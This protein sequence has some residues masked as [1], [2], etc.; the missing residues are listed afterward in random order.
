MDLQDQLQQLQKQKE[1]LLQKQA[2]L[3]EDLK[4]RHSDIYNWFLDDSIDLRSLAKYSANI[5]AALAIV[6]K[7]GD[8]SV[9]W[10]S[11][12]KTEAPKLEPVVRLIEV[13]ELA[14]KTEDEKVKLV[15]ER[16]GHIIKRAAEKY[17]VDEKLILATI[18][19]ESGG[20]TYAVRQEPQIN[21]ASYGL[22]QILYGTARGM[23]FKGSAEEM[24]DPEV[25]IELTARYH[26]RNMDV[27]GQELTPTQL[28]TAY[29]AGSPY[30]TPY[31][32]HLTK[33]EKWYEKVGNLLV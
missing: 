29:N 20:N 7:P 27:Y 22:G 21:D 17:S 1:Q 23:G 30:S 16:Y 15:Q 13:D 6:L 18:M 24:F 4:V 25:N 19:L 5:A 31:P 8:F 10:V 12:K 28:T 26:R 3:I 9:K 11:D 32:G 14:G 33:F 2:S